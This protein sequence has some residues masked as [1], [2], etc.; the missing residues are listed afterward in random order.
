MA[1]FRRGSPYNGNV[2]YPWGVWKHCDF[3]PISRFISET[4]QNR[5]SDNRTL[6]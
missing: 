5:N 1:K 2:D 4:I 3:W 6:L